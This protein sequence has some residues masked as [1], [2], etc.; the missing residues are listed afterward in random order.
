MCH[1]DPDYL[2]FLRDHDKSKDVKSVGNVLEWNVKWIKYCSTSD[3]KRSYPM[4]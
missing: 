4:K 2:V 1:D 3:G